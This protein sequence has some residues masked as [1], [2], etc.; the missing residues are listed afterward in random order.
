MS[1]SLRKS[2]KKLRIEILERAGQLTDGQYVS[3]FHEPEKSV[4]R[5]LFRE[6]LVSGSAK[7]SGGVGLTGLRDAGRDYL[8]AQRPLQKVKRVGKRVLFVAYSALLVVAG[9][10]LGLESVKKAISDFVGRFL[11]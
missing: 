2:E 10:V 9:H 1:T 7:E 3:Y 6:G 4:A 11:H 8:E 5:E